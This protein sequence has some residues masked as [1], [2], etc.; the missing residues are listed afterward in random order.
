MSSAHTGDNEIRIPRAA[1]GTAQEARPIDNSHSRTVARD[2]RGNIRI[3]F[4]V[5]ALA[6]HDQP[7]TSGKSLPQGQRSG[8]AFPAAVFRHIQVNAPARFDRPRL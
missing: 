6:P 8:L 3:G 2:Q 4:V 5:A 1:F 7:Y